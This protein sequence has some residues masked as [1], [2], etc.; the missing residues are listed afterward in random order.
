M[1]NILI[2]DDQPERF[3]FFEQMVIGKYSNTGGVDV[4]NNV[5][6]ALQKLS[7]K[8][9]DVAIVDMMIPE[10][11]WGQSL[12]LGGVKLLTHI[13]EDDSLLTP[14]YVIGLTAATDEVLEVA[15]FF[16]NSPWVLIKE[17]NAGSAWEQRIVALLA[18]ASNLENVQKKLD[19]GIDICFVTALAEPEQSALFRL[20][21]TWAPDP[22]YVDSN[23]SVRR[24]SLRAKG[25]ETLTV[26]AGCSMRMG[27]TEAALLTAKL[28]ERYRPKLVVMAGIC[29]GMQKKVE[30]GDALLGS[31]V[32]DWTS[33]KWDIDEKGNERTLP[34]PHFIECARELVARFRLL[35]QDRAFLDRVRSGWP[36]G[37]PPSALS[38][39]VG[40]VASG[41]IVVADGKTLQEIK[42]TQHRDV[43]GLEMEA[44]GVYCA[45]SFAGRPRPLVMS[46]K[47]VCDFADPRKNDEMQKY[48]SYTSANIVFE[49]LYRFGAELCTMHSG[50]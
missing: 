39:H 18:H 8:I 32:W 48:A 7:E 31:P 6:D 3:A 2:V 25:G 14:R 20:P 24:G 46:I 30:Y 44:Y 34:S 47:S 35:Q 22:E 40:P 12:S 29:A 5:R 37:A 28:I 26:V 27:A 43:L 21:M 23:T 9:Y 38:M 42:T 49:F 33:S 16:N 41:P 45:T 19:F 4:V 10:T 50:D 1:L 36:A 17:G 15:Q 13:Q 11:P